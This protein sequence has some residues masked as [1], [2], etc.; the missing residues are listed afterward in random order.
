MRRAAVVCVALAASVAAAQELTVEGGCRD[1][2]PHGAYEVKGPGGTVRAVGAFAK[3][4]R[5]G[6]FLFWSESGARVAH[7]PYDDDALSG[8]VAVWYPPAGR[9]GD[10][11]PK[12]EASYARGRLAGTKRSWYPDGR[13]RA[14][15]RYE[16]GELAAARAYAES[17][18]ALPE[19]EARAFAQRDLAADDRYL[20]SLEAFVRAA[21]TDRL[22]RG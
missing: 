2:Q 21:A 7:L 9:A 18:R 15:Y 22:E 16:Q 6:S 12:L 19:S 3:G 1:G 5:T 8:T 17:G 14:E 11:R 4:R 10:A 20:A 13:L